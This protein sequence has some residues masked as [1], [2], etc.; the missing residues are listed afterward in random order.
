[1]GR[2]R[3]LIVGERDINRALLAVSTLLIGST[4][5]NLS[6]SRRMEVFNLFKVL[7]HVGAVPSRVT[8]LFP[9]IVIL[10]T[11]TSLL[12]DMLISILFPSVYCAWTYPNE[13]INST[14][15]TEQSTSGNGEAPVTHILLRSG[16]NERGKSSA[17]SLAIPIN[18]ETMS[19][20]FDLN[21][22]QYNLHA[23]SIHNELIIGI[24]TRLEN[25]NSNILVFRDTTSQG[26]A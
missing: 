21:K 11:T 22:V 26:Q 5:F 8:E 6:R 12:G 10:Q 19:V 17:N 2:L 7:E 1:M 4:I 13:A 16:R 18:C 24:R 14:T 3:E 23:R 20:N 25:S 15:T 9:S